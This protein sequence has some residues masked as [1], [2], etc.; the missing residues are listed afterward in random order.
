MARPRHENPTP[1]ELEILQI[2]WEHGPATV[3][4]VVDA[5]HEHKPRAYTTVM[6]LMNTMAAKGLLVRRSIGKAFIYSA[7]APREQTLSK[8]LS[9][10]L[11]RAF[12]GSAEALVAHLLEKT[13]PD[14]VEE[15]RKTIDAYRRK[16]GRT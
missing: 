8:L 6:S 16:R 5:Q 9:D 3:R 12:R 1:A 7:A 15:I 10:L 11:R 4:Q 14:E 2:L 13:T